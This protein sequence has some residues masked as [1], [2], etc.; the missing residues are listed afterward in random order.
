V[1]DPRE[2]F[3]HVDFV[4]WYLRYPLNYRDLESM[5]QERGF[6]IITVRSTAGFLLMR[7][8]IEKRFR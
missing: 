1:S 6:E 3:A 5:F 2:L 4:S 7:P 8:L